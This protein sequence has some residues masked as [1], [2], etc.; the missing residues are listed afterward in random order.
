[1]SSSPSSSL[2]IAWLTPFEV[3][4]KFIP[5][6]TVFTC[7]SFHSNLMPSFSHRSHR[8]KTPHFPVIFGIG[9]K[10]GA[11]LHRTS[12][13]QSLRKVT[14]IQVTTQ[15]SEII[16]PKDKPDIGLQDTK[17]TVADD[18]PLTKSICRNVSEYSPSPALVA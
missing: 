17:K 1:M 6:M 3:G 13:G 11:N 9:S 10:H 2:Y 14:E 18:R 12:A 4:S 7:C 8:F 5:S 16:A 15:H